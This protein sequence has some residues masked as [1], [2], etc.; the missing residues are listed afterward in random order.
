MV[1]LYWFHLGRGQSRPSG[2]GRLE[3]LGVAKAVGCLLDR[4]SALH[5][6][7]AS[8][9]TPVKAN[10]SGAKFMTLSTYA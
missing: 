6:R 4:F 8:L 3:G 2:D 10:W 9:G 5:S 1:W 7:S